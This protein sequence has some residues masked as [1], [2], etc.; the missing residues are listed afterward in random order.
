MASA[1]A[2]FTVV[3]LMR[4][5]YSVPHQYCNHLGRETCGLS[6]CCELVTRTV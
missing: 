5:D 4:L 2:G 3:R 1:G 6:V